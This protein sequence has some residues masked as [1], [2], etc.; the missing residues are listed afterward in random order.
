MR[1]NTYV[2]SLLVLMKVKTSTFLVII[3]M[4]NMNVILRFTAT[5]PKNTTG[6]SKAMIDN[7]TFVIDDVLFTSQFDLYSNISLSPNPSN[8]DF[9]ISIDGAF[10]I[11]QVSIIAITGKV[12]HSVNSEEFTNNNSFVKTSLA[13][14]SYFVKI[15]TSNNSSIKKLIV[16]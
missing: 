6:P 5:I 3:G 9:L 13:A 7:I 4:E 1:G 8:G 11:E 16:R 15:N 10:I 14:G 2:L 12:V